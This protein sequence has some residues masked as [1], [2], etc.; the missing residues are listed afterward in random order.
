MSTTLLNSPSLA[1]TS[2]GSGSRGNALLVQTARSTLL[3]DCGIG[4]RRLG[5]ALRERGL[6]LA[7]MGC[8]LLTH[9][10]ADHVR[11]LPR[12]AALDAPIVATRGSANASG[13][14]C[15][16]CQI[17]SGDQTVTIGDFEVTAILVRHDASE[18]C[19]FR[20]STPDGVVTVL[21]DLGS[22]S[23]GTVEAVSAADLVVIE[24]N[25]DEDL[26]RRGPYP[27]H[28]QR[29]ILSDVGHL[30]N[31]AA[32]ELLVQALHHSSRIPEIWLAHLSETNNRPALAIR[33]INERLLAIGIR[34]QIAALPQREASTTWT[35]NGSPRAPRQLTLGV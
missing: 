18:P 20:I 8:L 2:L 29:R 19:G 31:H 27:R 33:T 9:E 14:G 11:E 24:A 4:S 34:A 30:S 32:A 26:L 21:T 22:F 28:L 5:P 23:D 15:G 17:I 12:I 6:A 7:D 1:V 35:P 3:V 25:H 13:V 10:H 16:R